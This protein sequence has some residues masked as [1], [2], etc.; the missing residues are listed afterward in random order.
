MKALANT[1]TCSGGCFELA[2]DKKA[3][4]APQWGK[5]WGK[6]QFREKTM[7]HKKIQSPLS[8]WI[9]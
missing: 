3:L 7:S 9:Y 2:A 4:L 5:K 8:D 1:Q 6:N